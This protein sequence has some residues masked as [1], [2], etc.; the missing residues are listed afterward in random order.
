MYDESFGTSLQPLQKITG[1]GIV[2][3]V[4]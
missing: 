4:R 2:T 1:R 3:L